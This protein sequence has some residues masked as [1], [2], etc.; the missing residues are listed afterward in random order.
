MQATL[1]RGLVASAQEQAAVA[2]LMEPSESLVARPPL[3]MP[4]ALFAALLLGLLLLQ[5]A[6]EPADDG[7]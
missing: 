7:E 4:R 2:E 1:G 6:D 5:P 3:Y